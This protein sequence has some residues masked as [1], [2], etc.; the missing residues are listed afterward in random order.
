MKTYN[1][2]I[3]MV[4]GSTLLGMFAQIYNSFNCIYVYKIFIDKHILYS[5]E[6]ISNSILYESNSFSTN[7]EI[8]K[9]SLNSE[10]M[11]ITARQ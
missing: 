1:A 9:N 7:Q 6:P 8:T 2:Q 3:I 5:S 10:F 4:Y 11:F